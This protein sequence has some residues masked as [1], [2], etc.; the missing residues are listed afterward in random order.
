M[1]VESSGDEAC[2]STKRPPIKRRRL[3]KT[4]PAVITSIKVR[5]SHWRAGALR[6]RPYQYRNLMRFAV[7]PV[8]IS[9]L[10]FMGTSPVGDTSPIDV[11]DF[12]AGGA[13]VQ[14][15]FTTMQYRAVAYDIVNDA[16]YQDLLSD[17]GWLTALSW[18][19]RLSEGGLTHWGTV[20]STWVWISR[21]S[22][23]PCWVNRML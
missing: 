23:G 10:L 18:A 16:T 9:M 1:E 22:T 21:S 7:P 12:F 8:L 5:T 17:E 4:S 2:C 15:A 19:N 11:I 13:S 20:C 6:I 14:K 3:R